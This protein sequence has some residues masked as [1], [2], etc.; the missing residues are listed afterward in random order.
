MNASTIFRYPSNLSPKI[1]IAHCKNLRVTV[2]IIS[3]NFPLPIFL[4]RDPK[5]TDGTKVLEFPTEIIVQQQLV[6]VHD[7]PAVV[8][9]ELLEKPAGYKTTT[10]NRVQVCDGEKQVS[11][12]P[13][14]D[15]VSQQGCTQVC[16]GNKAVQ[17]LNNGHWRINIVLDVTVARAEL[18]EKQAGF[19]PIVVH[20]E[21]Q[22][23]EC[24]DNVL[25][26]ENC[27]AS[28]NDAAESTGYEGDFEHVSEVGHSARFDEN[29]DRPI[30]LLKNE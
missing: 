24:V 29:Q 11:K 28:E 30:H 26:N 22:E 7:Q 13:T 21:R 15:R 9:A 17:Q 23:L 6:Q 4:K 20:D 1:I 12:D 3:S 27:Q 10:L 2:I 14:V 25:K 8:D 16:R 5:A 19:K 18:V